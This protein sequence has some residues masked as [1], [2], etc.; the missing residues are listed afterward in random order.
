MCGHLQLV[1]SFFTLT[2]DIFLP[3]LLFEIGLN[4]CTN[5]STTNTANALVYNVKQNI[6]KPCVIN[7]KGFALICM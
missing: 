3:E 4:T 7:K 1:S 5:N 2:T 6:E